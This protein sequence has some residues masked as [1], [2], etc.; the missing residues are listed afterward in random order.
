[1]KRPLTDFFAYGSGIYR[2]VASANDIPRTAG[3]LRR[4]LAEMGNPWVVDR[5]LGDD[6]PLPEYPMGSQRAEDLPE[7]LR[8]SP[9][10]T[11]SLE[12]LLKRNVPSNPFLRNRWAELGLQEAGDFG[13][14]DGTTHRPT[15]ESDSRSD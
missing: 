5:R 14:S 7:E 9:R 3:E 12:E 4:R 11:A 10:T 13:I 2:P 6:D 8:N 1:M 15:D